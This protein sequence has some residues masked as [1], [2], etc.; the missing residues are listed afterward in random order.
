MTG[1]I[2]Q[3]AHWN[4]RKDLPLLGSGFHSC[5]P[6]HEGLP[7]FPWRSRSGE[8]LFEIVT[9]WGLRAKAWID[10]SHEFM[11]EGAKWV[12]AEGRHRRNIDQI[13]VAAWRRISGCSALSQGHRLF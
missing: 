3:S 4:E 5:W 9:A 10:D 13:Q 6:C 2:E 8:A 12:I 7:R 1:Q 11:A